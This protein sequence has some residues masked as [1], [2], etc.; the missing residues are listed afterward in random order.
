MGGLFSAAMALWLLATVNAMLHDRSPRLLRDGAERRLLRPP[1]GCTLAGTAPGSR[2]SRQ[3]I[4][5]CILI[6]F[7]DAAKPLISYIGFT[8]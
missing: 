7:G 4:C 6:M 3:G 1:R 5:T 2:C 8:L